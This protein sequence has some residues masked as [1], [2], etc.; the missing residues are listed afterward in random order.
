VDG[1]LLTT[2]LLS[3]L[4]GIIGIVQGYGLGL[5]FMKG[6]GSLARSGRA[7]PAGRPQEK[8]MNMRT[9]R[10]VAPGRT[11]TARP[12]YDRRPGAWPGGLGAGLLLIMTLWSGD[13]AEG[14]EP[15]LGD[16]RPAAPDQQLQLAVHHGRLSVALLGATVREL[17]A[18]IAHQ[19]GIIIHAGVSAEKRTSVE[20]TDVGLE[21]GLRRLLRGASLSYAMRY[22]RGPSETIALI[23][24]H[25]F[26]DAQQ[27]T[28]PLRTSAE[29]DSEGRTEETNP[30]VATASSQDLGPLSPIPPVGWNEASQSAAERLGGAQHE[31]SSTASGQEAQPAP[32]L[33]EVLEYVRQR[34]SNR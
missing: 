23:D 3:M 17:L 32:S 30:S 7:D 18:Q 29:S 2:S 4:A 28:Q 21:D 1:L 33:H 31:M 11:P 9:A 34:T 13:W 14:R 22:A 24:V 25:V 6:R 10:E 27:G 15:A 12:P 16:T 20:F 19:A 5:R 26:E 8:F